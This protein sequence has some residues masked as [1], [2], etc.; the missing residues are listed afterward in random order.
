[1]SF[2]FKWALFYTS[3]SPLW[4][5]IVFIDV[6]NII[7]SGK[8]LTTEY[9]SI[10]VI[11]ITFIITVKI[12]HKSI[13]R[14]SEASFQM[15]II[16]DAI[17]E[18]GITSEFL[19]SYILPLFAFD[20][21][22]WVSVVQFLFYFFVL[23]FLCIRNNNIY[24]NVILEIFKYKFYSCELALE[25]EK[26]NEQ[27]NAIVISNKNLCSKKNHTVQASKLDSPFYVTKG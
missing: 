27:I 8:N 14:I 19:L 7:N 20:F 10:S 13:K 3:F 9:I 6:I 1:M 16:K 21:T 12:I 5:T 17:Q 2:Y 18:K 25:A 22:S 4:L 11:L 24:A 15:Y 23:S 26:D